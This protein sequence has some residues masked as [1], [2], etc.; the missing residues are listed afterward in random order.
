MYVRSIFFIIFLVKTEISDHLTSN[1]PDFTKRHFR[2][3]TL[4]KSSNTSFKTTCKLTFCA[5]SYVITTFVRAV[6]RPNTFFSK[7][8]IGTFQTAVLPKVAVLTF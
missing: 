6:T 2:T 8:W 1:V 7:Q 3:N 4:N 5:S